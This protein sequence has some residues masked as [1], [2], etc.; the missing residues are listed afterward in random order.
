MHQDRFAI[1]SRELID[2]LDLRSRLT[3]ERDSAQDAEEDRILSDRI[4]EINS[5]LLPHLRK[6]I[7]DAFNA[8]KAIEKHSLSELIKH[9]DD[10]LNGIGTFRDIDVSEARLDFLRRR[11]GNVKSHR[12]GKQIANEI[13]AIE[14]A[15]SLLKE[16]QRAVANEQARREQNEAEIRRLDEILYGHLQKKD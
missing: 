16:Q 13:R 10:A 12:E 6:Q 15:R 3:Q 7:H 14:R 2:L 4:A 9:I 8:A 1:F 5:K 11:Q